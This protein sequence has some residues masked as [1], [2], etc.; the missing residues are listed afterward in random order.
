[1][2]RVFS[3]GPAGGGWRQGSLRYPCDA[4]DRPKEV[5]IPA[6]VEFERPDGRSL[7]P[8]QRESFGIHTGQTPAPL[9]LTARSLERYALVR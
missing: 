8:Y 5:E 4:F 9:P 1:M 3:A 2:S 7:G 6:F